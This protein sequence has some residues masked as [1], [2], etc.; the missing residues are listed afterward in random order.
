VNFEWTKR[1]APAV[2]E[3]EDRHVEQKHRIVHSPMAP[4]RF[5]RFVREIA[6]LSFHSRFSFFE[7]LFST[8]LPFEVIPS[9]WF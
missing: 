7:G 8:Y 5:S 2:G 9:V 1:S 6:L 4:D 3:I